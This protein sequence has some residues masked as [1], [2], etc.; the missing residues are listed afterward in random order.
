LFTDKI[1][2]NFREF[3]PNNKTCFARAGHYV[4]VN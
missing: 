4:T 3:F 2:S 1:S